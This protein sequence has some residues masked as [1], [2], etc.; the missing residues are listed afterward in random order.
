MTFVG[1]KV[2]IKQVEIHTPGMENVY[3]ALFSAFVGLR[4]GIPDEKIKTGLKNFHA[5]KPGVGIYTVGEVTFIEDSASAT[6]E[7]VKMRLIRFAILQRCI[8]VRERSL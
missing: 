4:Y 6:A 5:S 2:Y 3:S 8:R 1:K 7:S